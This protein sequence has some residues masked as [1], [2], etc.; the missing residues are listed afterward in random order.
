MEKAQRRLMEEHDILT[1]L[2][3]Q[4]FAIWFQPISPQFS[5][6]SIRSHGSDQ[7]PSACRWRSR[8]SAPQILPLAMAAAGDHAAVVGECL[9]TAVA[10]S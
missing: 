2:E 7:P 5:I 9:V 10:A 4:Q 8:T 6:R 1:A 3:N